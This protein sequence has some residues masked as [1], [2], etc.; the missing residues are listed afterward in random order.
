[1]TPDIQ[2]VRRFNREVTKRIGVLHDQFLGRNRPVGES[3][4]LFE[5]G[6]DGMEVRNLRTRLGLDSGYVSRLLRAL[7][8]QGLVETVA[9]AR[10]ARIR[11][12][13][14]TPSGLKEKEELDRRSDA[15]AA[16]LL[17]PLGPHQR[18]R[19]IA[20]MAEVE[21]LLRA[22]DIEITQ[23]PADS[24][25]ANWCLDQYF[26][27]LNERFEGGYDPAKGQPTDPDDFTPPKGIFLLARMSGKPVGCGALKSASP[28]IGEIKRLWV[29]QSTRGLG[30]GQQLL[31]ALEDEARKLG[32][33]AI[34][35]DTNRSL[36]EAQALYLK[37]GYVEVP[38]FND[39]PYPDHFF[40][41]RL[42]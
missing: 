28:A 41:K 7:E 38:R 27:L 15:A 16:S 10:D 3:R 4:L 13:R 25:T 19:L 12:A 5:I 1:M 36:T 6:A 18:E 23:E 35:L 37:N 9:A 17:T 40:E 11:H 42:D 29:A 22:G 34:R 14:L 32:M 2:Q 33:V 26:E 30:L 21:R 20:A 31:S 8:R 39:D 24:K